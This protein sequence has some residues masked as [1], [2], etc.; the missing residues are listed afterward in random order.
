MAVILHAELPCRFEVL[1]ARVAHV[2]GQ[3]HAF[4]VS[5]QQHGGAS[6]VRGL[7]FEF[8]HQPQQRQYVVAAVENVTDH[9]QLV[10]PVAPP[11]AAVDHAVGLEERCKTLEI[12]VGIGCD[13]QFR[14][15]PE[16]PGTS[17]Y[18]V[19]RDAEQIGIPARTDLDGASVVRHREDMP[20]LVSDRRIGAL[21][22]VIDDVGSVGRVFPAEVVFRR[23]RFCGGVRRREGA[24]RCGQQQSEQQG[25]A[26]HTSVRFGDVIRRPF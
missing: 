7:L 3:H 23:F 2:A 20:P 5:Q 10:V 6:R 9:H 19:R 17:F 8:V 15:L 16:F 4:V 18:G 11:V 25:Q 12:A 21:L 13:E 22:R 14:G 24:E 1:P 26:F